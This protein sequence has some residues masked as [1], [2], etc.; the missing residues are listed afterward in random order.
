MEYKHIR[1]C[2]NALKYCKT[3]DEMIK[4]VATFPLWAGTWTID[5]EEEDHTVLVINEWY[6]ENL[7]DYFTDEDTYDLTEALE[8]KEELENDN[9]DDEIT[10]VYV[11]THCAASENYMPEVFKSKEEAMRILNDWYNSQVEYYAD[12]IVESF[13]GPDFCQITWNDDT[14]DILKIF[15]CNI[16]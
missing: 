16:H 12:A 3:R 15:D 14:Y 13:C 5:P 6:D 1:D 8:N 10:T 2:W 11:L 4:T 9:S 7:D